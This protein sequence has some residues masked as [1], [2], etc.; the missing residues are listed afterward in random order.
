MG[1]GV[2]VLLPELFCTFIT[3]DQ[4]PL[5]KALGHQNFH[6]IKIKHIEHIY[7]ILT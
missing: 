4:I 6:K 2:G 7:K 5:L 1:L 3:L